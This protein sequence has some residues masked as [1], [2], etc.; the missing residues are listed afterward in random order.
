MT[1]LEVRFKQAFALH[2]QGR[3]ADAERVYHE[4]LRERANHFDTLH[5]L[6][7]IALQT[8][9]T[10][11]GVELIGQAIRVNGKN[12]AAYS[13]R[14]NG[15]VEL[16]RPEEA[17]ASYD[18]AIALKPDYADAY[19]NRGNG[20]LELKRPE[21]AVASY[22]KAIAL[23]PDYAEA[24]YNRG[25]G[26]LELKRPEEAVESYDKAIAL[27]PDYAEAYSNRGNGLLEL[28]RPEEAVASYDKAIAVKPDYAEA[29]CNQS[30]CRLAMGDYERGWE[31]YEWRSQN[32]DSSQPPKINAP[33][34][35][36]EEIDGRSI[37]AF[38]EQ[39][40]GDVIQFARFL[41]MLVRR[42]AK[43][44]FLCPAKLI[45]LLR[46]LCAQVEF[47]SSIVGKGPFDF[48]SALMSLPLRFKT[49]L[50]SIPG[51]VS[52]LKPEANLVD[53]WKQR[54]GE[55]GFRIGIVWQGTPRRK[56]DQGRSFPLS[57]IV[58]LSLIPGVRLISLQ[59]NDG[60]EQLTNLPTAAA[61]E[62][63]GDEFDSGP[64]AFIDTAAVMSNL[65]LII[66]SDTSIAHLAGA[67]G[68][69]TWVALKYVPDWRWLLDRKDSP[70]YPTICLFRQQTA[71]DWKSVF[72]TIAQELR[73]LV[74]GQN[75]TPS[76][77]ALMNSPS[78]PNVQVSWGELLDKITILEIKEQ[79]LKSPKAVANVRR[80]LAILR[81][82]AKDIDAIPE[83]TSLKEEL[84]SVNENLWKIE[85]DI[86][87]K[88]LYE[89]FDHQFIE[90]ARSVYVHND[91]RG[92][93]KRRI[94]EFTGSEVIE[95]KQYTEYRPA[96]PRPVTEDGTAE[97]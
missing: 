9:R 60:L 46:P 39:G 51:Q 7:V 18:K 67:L 96:P 33:K 62:T 58:P 14:G 91:R 20:L 29:Y 12:A 82:A 8:R 16:K 68:R 30:L 61:V 52:Y 17:V 38:G 88:E 72:S 32:E 25:N 83:L 76:P 37:L 81:A 19:Y 78:S 95:E 57:E 31:M 50:G 24:Y 90:L 54:I 94:N 85:D 66:T 41:P 2:Q 56:I 89:T 55:T 5:L 4:V 26:L 22:D 49:D 80:E 74:G 93:L 23:K 77:G 6:G 36:G 97:R 15:L 42:G 34:W 84:R 13:N 47:I 64:D 28:K 21:E 73:S 65:D 35:Q 70:W 86:R 43:V 45:R 40:L 27:K 59:K 53:H 69:P 48:Q 10:E 87:A 71:G 11:L 3:L 1:E 92:L 75:A 63:L 79:R 44:T